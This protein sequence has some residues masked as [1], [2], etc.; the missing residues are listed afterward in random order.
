MQNEGVVHHA[1]A[2]EFCQG[3][4]IERYTRRRLWAAVFVFGDWMLGGCGYLVGVCRGGGRGNQNLFSLYVL[5]HNLCNSVARDEQATS[6]THTF[7]WEGPNSVEILG[8][9]D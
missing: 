6:E 1:S 5:F 7:P 2:V 9:K 4:S 3:P 8:R